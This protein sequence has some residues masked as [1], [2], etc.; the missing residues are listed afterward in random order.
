MKSLDQIEARTPITNTASLVILAQPGSYYL[1]HNLTVT[2]GDGIDIFTSGVTLDLNGFTIASTAATATGNGISLNG[3][4]SDITIAN[5]HIRG[6]VTNNGSGVYGGSGFAY[7]IYYLY[8]PAVNVL[9]SRVSVSGCQIAGIYL[10]TGSSTVVDSCTVRT[11][12]SY[13]IVASTIKNCWAMDCGYA[14][15]YG[16]QV[17]DA[18]GQGSGSGYGIYASATA[19]N[20]DGSSSSSGFGLYA[21]VTAQNC[22]GSG[23]T[24]TGLYASVTLNC[25]GSSTSGDGLE[26][27]TAQNCIGYSSGGGYGLYAIYIASDCYGYSNSG[28]GLSAFIANICHGDSSTGAFLST[29]HGVNSY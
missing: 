5:G 29:T 28:M 25:Y 14:G 4:L 3:S 26:A 7:G 15:I 21:A 11:V 20:C 10:S 8:G 12:G 19:Q 1:T 13:G 18:H 6:G 2:G 27:T 22:Y 24:G 16:D 17:A 9:I 23:G